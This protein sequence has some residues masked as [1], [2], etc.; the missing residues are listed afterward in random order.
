MNIYSNIIAKEN[1]YAAAHKAM[2]G[3]L[4][5]PRFYSYNANLVANVERIARS[6]YDGVYKQHNEKEFDLWCIS[7]QKMRHIVCPSIDDLIVQHAIYR[8]IVPIIDPKLIFDSYGCR[9]G[10]GTHRASTR[11]QFFLRNSS[12]ESYF[13]QTDIRKYYYNLD[14]ALLKQ[15]LMHLLGDE[16]AVEFIAL[17][18]PTGQTVGLNVGAMISQLMGMIYLNQFDHYVK[19][20]LKIKHYIRY[21]DDA[22]YIGLSKE[23]CQ[24]LAQVTAEYLKTNLKLTYSKCKVIPISKG[25]NFVGYRSWQAKKIIRKRSYKTFRKNLRKRKLDSLQSCLGHAKNTSSY[26]QLVTCIKENKPELLEFLKV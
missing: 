2:L 5:S 18:F 3:K 20:V 10:K 26:K 23:E 4:S 6:I 1:L 14:H 12:P 15:T 9:L 11:C 16:K 25:V 22:V 21:V 17:Q 24:E 13:L 7:G 8:V 19:R